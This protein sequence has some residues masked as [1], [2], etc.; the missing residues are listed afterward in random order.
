MSKYLCLTFDDGPNN[1]PGDNTMNDMLD[2]LE[3]YDIPASFFLIGN[4]ITEENKKV[5]L[6][7]VE[8]GC[9]IQN[10]SWSHGFMAQMTVQQIKEEYK[11]CDDAITQLTGVR[12]TFFRPPYLNI[13]QT[14]YECISVPF[15]CGCGCNDWE[16]DKDAD[17]RY[18]VMKQVTQN[19]VLYLL[20]VSE[21]NKATLDAVE[22]LIPELK[23]QG[24]EFVNL[25]QLFE[26]CGVN[27][28]KDHA[29]W[30]VATNNENENIWQG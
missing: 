17:Y 30:S 3:K 1:I 21:G 26:K 14:M 8:L 11:K 10:H 19:G 20:H 16:P 23:E 27:P 5:I 24:Y 2:I 13:S 4:K 25:P 6:R 12:P 28:Q 9:D 22:R 15:I 29:L 7:A 18:N